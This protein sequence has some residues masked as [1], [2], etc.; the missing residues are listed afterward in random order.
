MPLGA[1][2]RDSVEKYLIS[3][4]IAGGG[5]GRIYRGVK[6]GIGGF[7]KHVVLK[8][9]LPELTEDEELVQLFFREAQIHAALDHANIV[10]IIDL[11]AAGRDYYIVMEYVRGTDLYRVLKALRRQK[12]RLPVPAALYVA[13]EVLKALDY[14]HSRVDDHGANLGIVHRDISPTNIMVS[15]AGEI[16]LTDF[17]IAKAASYSTNFFKVRGKAAYMSPEQARGDELDHRADIY[18]TAVCLYEMLTDQ[19][20]LPSPKVGIG[21]DAH[22]RQP[23]TPICELAEDVPKELEELV[24]YGLAV[25]PDDRPQT[26]GELLNGIEQVVAEHG[27]FC[28]T[29]RLASFL[30]QTL[31]ADP[32]QWAGN[33]QPVSRPQARSD[34]SLEL[35]SPPKPVR[36]ASE[37]ATSPASAEAMR[38]VRETSDMRGSSG[39]V[40][41]S[42]A[43]GDQS[44]GK[45]VTSLSLPPFPWRGGARER[46]PASLPPPKRSLLRAS[47]PGARQVDPPLPGPRRADPPPP[48]PRRADPPPPGP[49][50]ADPSSPS[51]RPSDPPPPG[52]PRCARAVGHSGPPRGHAPPASPA[53]AGQG[54]PSQTPV[55][56]QRGSAGVD[57]TLSVG[58][59]CPRAE[60]APRSAGMPS[61]LAWALFG[62]GLVVVGMLVFWLVVTVAG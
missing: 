44:V 39:G 57:R 7:E 28:S 17:G 62:V 2:E 32:K 12:R 35:D 20:P 41:G 26:A 30:A 60:H 38:R 58:A 5:M 34:A 51:P 54:D 49:R 11:V 36:S 61:W 52:P 24:M 33:R 10:H 9:L 50:R 3:E 40:E 31:G 55:V 19:R 16:K 59:H 1:G 47:R 4:R 56:A 21:A 29:N 6:K 43:S 42:V 37:A 25:E 23:I 27:W 53:Q 14:A 46:Q 48:G 13:R 22:Y 15:G 8:Q 45:E 18:S